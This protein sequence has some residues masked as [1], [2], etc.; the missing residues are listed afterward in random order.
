MFIIE[1]L[2]NEFMFPIA[3]TIACGG[4]IYQMW[5]QEKEDN[6][7]REEQQREDS[8]KREERM[9]QEMNNIA[10]TLSVISTSMT[11]ITKSIENL[12]SRMERLE[13]KN[14]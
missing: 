9:F 8:N 1:Q 7:K 4:F 6:R 2:F 11:D 12:N 5:Q 10:S 14:E 3:C 13:N